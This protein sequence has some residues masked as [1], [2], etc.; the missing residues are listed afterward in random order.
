MNTGALSPS[1]RNLVPNNLQNEDPADQGQ[2]FESGVL[3][4]EDQNSNSF[5][6]HDLSKAS[7]V[8][9]I[10]SISSSFINLKLQSPSSQSQNLNSKR[11]VSE[12]RN[13][14]PLDKEEVCLAPISAMIVTLFENGR[15][16][17]FQKDTHVTIFLN[18]SVDEQIKSIFYNRLNQSIIVVSVTKKDEYNSLKCRSVPLRLI[19]QAFEKVTSYSNPSQSFFLMKKEFKGQKL[20][21][22]FVLRWP[23]FVEFDELNGKIITKHS[24][25]DSYRIW[26]LSSYTLQFV[27][28]EQNVA[29][30]KICNGVMLLL[31]NYENDQVPMTLIKVKTGEELMKFKFVNIS[32][33]IEFLE[34]FNEKIMIKTC[35]KDLIIYNTKTQQKIKVKGFQAPEA[36]I[37][38]YE[39]EKILTLKDGKVQMWTSNGK[40][41]CD[42]GGQVLCT[43]APSV[44]E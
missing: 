43:R 31:H 18:K 30:F 1:G 11:L 39:Q 7:S 25:E 19:Q 20:F 26:C 42:F 5:E 28:K 44:Q 6:N 10:I 38:L 22:D 23:D 8:V 40:M 13:E 15:C 36:F 29:E 12:S 14:D 24:L 33:E 17:I 41:I 27:I 34:Q 32:K 3:N 2:S 35:D 4:P 21:S 37:F 16:A 9:E